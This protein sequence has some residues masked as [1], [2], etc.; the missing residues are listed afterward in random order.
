MHAMTGFARCGV[1]HTVGGGGG[2][3]W[4]G[5]VVRLVSRPQG[6]CRGNN[7]YA[8]NFYRF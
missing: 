4:G 5:E 3:A 7:Y 1:L 6:L 2:G 8:S